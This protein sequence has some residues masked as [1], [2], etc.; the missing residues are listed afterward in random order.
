MMGSDK[1]SAILEVAREDEAGFCL[2]LASDFTVRVRGLYE[3]SSDKSVERYKAFN[4][5]MHLTVNQAL[6]A[7]RDRKRYSLEDFIRILVKS[8]EKNGLGAAIQGSVDVLLTR[9]M[10]RKPG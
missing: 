3:L 1:L 2:Q 10:S 7:V 8:A 5:L 4:E 9:N 6:N